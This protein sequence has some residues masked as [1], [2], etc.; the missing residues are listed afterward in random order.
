M[1]AV[2]RRQVV[3]VVL[4]CTHAMVVLELLL[5]AVFPLQ[6]LL[7]LV[8]QAAR[9]SERQLAQLTA[10][11]VRPALRALLVLHLLLADCLGKAAVVEAVALLA[12]V[13]QA[14]LADAAQAAV[15][16]VQHAVHTP[17]APV[18]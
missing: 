14:A 11:A 13:E 9:D 5:A 7:L 3:R 17:Q 18:V 1:V 6:T 12:Q 15:V 10:Q 4:A 16:V 2:G 8:V